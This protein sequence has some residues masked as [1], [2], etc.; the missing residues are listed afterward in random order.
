MSYLPKFLDDESIS[1]LF[2][3]SIKKT[4]MNSML[5]MIQEL[6]N[7]AKQIEE[8]MDKKT[9]K[10]NISKEKAIDEDYSKTID[11]NNLIIMDIIY[12]KKP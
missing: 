1:F 4:K 11:I 10:R 6:S 5:K 9:E 3:Y 2:S 12:P 8:N 7:K